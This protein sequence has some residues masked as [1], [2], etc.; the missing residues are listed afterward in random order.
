MFRLTL[1]VQTIYYLVTALWPLVHIES[2]MDV[3]GPKTDI[4][5][6]KTVGTLLIPI[7]C[8]FLVHL[9]MRINHW[10]VVV[11]AAASCIGLACIDVYYV[12]KGVIDEIYLGDA[13]AEIILLIAWIIVIVR[14]KNYEGLNK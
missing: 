7:S 2:F 3:T 14:R 11:L 6:V 8:C 9:F 4:W 13:A 1:W 12:S 5:L 10:P